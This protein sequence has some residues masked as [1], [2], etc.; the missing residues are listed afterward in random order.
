MGPRAG[1]DGCGKS[2]TPT[3]IRSPDRPAR[4]EWLYPAPKHIISQIN[5]VYIKNLYRF[6][7]ISTG[8]QRLSINTNINS[9][10]Q[11]M[12]AFIRHGVQ[13]SSKSHALQHDTQVFTESAVRTTGAP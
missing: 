1:L 13:P 11:A 3:G 9:R 7:L 6:T 10:Y 2:R 12:K 8:A 5:P 4:S